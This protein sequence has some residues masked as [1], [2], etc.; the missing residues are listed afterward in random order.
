MAAAD[1]TLVRSD[2]PITIVQAMADGFLPEEP[3]VLD[4]T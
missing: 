3:D 1:A 4:P 2:H